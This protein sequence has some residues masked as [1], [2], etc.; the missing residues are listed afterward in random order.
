MNHPSFETLVSEYSNTA[1]HNDRLHVELT[2]STWSDPL[3]SQH[4]KYIEENKLGFGDAAFHSMWS[5]LLRAAAARFGSVRA[6]EIGVFKGQVISLLSLLA[7]EHG[8]SLSIEGITPLSGNPLPGSRLLR[9]IKSAL[10]KKF[11]ED[12]ENG[13]FYAVENYHDVI[14]N[15]FRRFDLNFED[16]KIYQGYSTDASIIEE[17]KNETYHLIYVDGDHS[18]AGALHDFK[19]YGPKVVLGG[20]LVADDAGCDL[21]GSSFWK[22]HDAVSRAVRELPA[23]GFKN[24]LNV[25]HNRIYE[26][27]E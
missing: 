25:G 20:W 26:R 6:L 2:K 3:L 12:L 23:M 9:F 1:E 4:R 24:I 7:R 16:V 18:Y 8:L 15:L 14:T 22:G 19:T 10:N 13:N 21:P 11:R 27:I 5:Y 17:T